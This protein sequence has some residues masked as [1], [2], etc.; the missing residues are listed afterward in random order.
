MKVLQW[1]RQ[2][3]DLNLIEMLWWD[4]KR[5]VHEQIMRTPENWS[6]VVKYAF[7]FIWDSNSGASYFTMDK[8]WYEGFGRN[9]LVAD[10]YTVKAL[11]LTYVIIANKNT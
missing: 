6:N 5:A 3:P 9:A 1:S 7:Y 4:L 10:P 11:L 8:M 2:S